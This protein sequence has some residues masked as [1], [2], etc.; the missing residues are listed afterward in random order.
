[1]PLS[2]INY[3]DEGSLRA[4]GDIS[5]RNLDQLRSYLEN[6]IV[7]KSNIKIGPDHINFF[8]E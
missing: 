7:V 1:M 8:F 4:V 2:Q 6:Q 5:E 3:F